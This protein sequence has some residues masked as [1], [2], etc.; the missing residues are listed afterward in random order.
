VGTL[1]LLSVWLHILAATTWLGGMLFL[2]L[3]IV[4]TLRRAERRSAATVMREAG[5]RFRTVGWACFCV[6]IVTGTYNAWWRGVR[7]QHLVEPAWLATIFGRTFALK[8][9]LFLVV[10]ALSVR[11]DFFVG[12]RASQ[13]ARRG[14]EA[15]PRHGSTGAEPV[16]AGRG[17]G[18]RRRLVGRRER[19][20][21]SSG[22]RRE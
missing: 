11:H 13:A 19:A 22:D 21:S 1:Y 5:R 4:P 8:M 18:S 15:G 3:V 16:C 9:L 7:L 2:V 12:P 10:L 6:L 17:P 20:A 14:F